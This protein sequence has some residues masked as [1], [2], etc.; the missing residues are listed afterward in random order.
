MTMSDKLTSK[1][2]FLSLVLR[3]KPEEIG[4]TLDEAGWVSVDVLLAALRRKGKPMTLAELREV[5]RTNDKQRFGF[6][7]DGLRIRANQGHSVEVD[8]DHA[9]AT[10]PETLFHGTAERNVASIRQTGLR[11]SQRHHVHLSENRQT[12]EAVGRRYGKLVLLTIRSAEMSR[13]GF[14]FYRTPNNVWLVDAVPAE[15]I[16]F[17]E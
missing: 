1:S 14:T 10:P 3:H 5:V 15:F 6:S 4:I 13:A 17:P 16:E 11:K 12:A 9:P 2:K 7:D 8:L